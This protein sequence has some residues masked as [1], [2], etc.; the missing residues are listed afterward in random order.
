MTRLGL[1]LVPFAVALGLAGC[2]Q[3]VQTPGDVGV[4]Y[5]LASVQNGKA[6][7]NVVAKGVPDMEHCA[8][9]LEAMRVRFLSLGGA[10]QE[11]T[12]AFQGNFL[13]LGP[14]GVFSGE[15]YTGPRYPFLVR[16]GDALVP[17]GSAPQ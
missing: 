12:G 8:A 15:T 11:I 14:E 16:S 9:Q 13:F 10:N 2:S 5:H 7:F 1:L 6:K 3:G 17:V 4:C